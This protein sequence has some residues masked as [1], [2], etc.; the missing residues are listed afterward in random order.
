MTNYP[1]HEKLK[2]VHDKSQII[3]EFIDWA[4]S[5]EVVLI[6]L[7]KNQHVGEYRLRQLLADFFEIDLKKLEAEKR[8]MFTEI[9]LHS[10]KDTSEELNKAIDD[11]TAVWET[12]TRPTF[13]DSMILNEAVASVAMDR[14]G[15]GQTIALGPE[16]I[17]EYTMHDH[18]KEIH[19]D[20]SCPVH[21]MPSHGDKGE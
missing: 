1:E 13:V 2:A 4:E 18:D 10:E 14:E 5:E 16:C 6:D 3:G 19:Y 12:D 20:A 9:R 11:G 21:G 17:C 8:H 15:D 7:D